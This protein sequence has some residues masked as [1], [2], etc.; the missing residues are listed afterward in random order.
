MAL[1]S[2]PALVLAAAEGVAV[3]GLSSRMRHTALGIGLEKPW[4]KGE[5]GAL[6]GLPA[7]RIRSGTRAQDPNMTGHAVENTRPLLRSLAGLHA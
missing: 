5:G 2:T 1:P 4:G 6:P 3:T 7:Q